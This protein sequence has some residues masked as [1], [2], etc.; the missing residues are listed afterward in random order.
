MPTKHYVK[1]PHHSAQ[2]WFHKTFLGASASYSKIFYIVEPR[3]W[4]ISRVGRYITQAIETS[5]HVDSQIK[6]SCRGISEQIIHFGSKNLLSQLEEENLHPANKFV[7]TWYH[8]GLE[9]IRVGHPGAISSLPKRFPFLKKIITSC[10]IGKKNLLAVGVPEMKIE[11]IPLGINLKRFG[12]SSPEQKQRIRKQFGIPPEAICIG[13][14]QKDG[15]GWG[16]GTEPK[17][18]K[19]PDIFLRTV[20]RLARRYPLFILLTGPSRGYVKHH[21]E[22]MGIPYRHFYFQEPD[23]LVPCYHCLDLYLITSR[24]EGGPLALLEAM[25]A[26]IPVVS[27][28]VGM[29]V[30]LL[31]TAENG[32]LVEPEDIEGLVKASEQLIKSPETRQRCA[33]K[34]LADIVPFDWSDIARQHYE[35][36]YKDLLVDH[37]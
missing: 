26:G 17:L 33:R 3:N 36:V 14:F 23:G 37:R 30:D 8:G 13:S 7:L 9:D 19:G 12:P 15:V 34:A 29:A 6:N 4:V 32:Y 24:D 1:S 25:A 27:T 28:K 18:V 21:L 11:V 10:T 22:K 5:Y 2:A 31:H 35:R 20:E 16:K